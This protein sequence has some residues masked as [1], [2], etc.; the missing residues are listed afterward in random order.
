MHHILP[1]DWQN[2]TSQPLLYDPI[3]LDFQKFK[4][5]VPFLLKTQ[6]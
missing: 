3:F 4:C 6:K 1:S 5:I 2:K